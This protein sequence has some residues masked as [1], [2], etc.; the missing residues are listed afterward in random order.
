MNCRSS[1]TIALFAS[2]LVAFSAHAEPLETPDPR[3][4][5]KETAMKLPIAQRLR[6]SN[7]LRITVK[8]GIVDEK[9]LMDL[10]DEDSTQRVEVEGPSSVWTVQKRNI[11]NAGDLVYITIDRYDFDAPP[12]QYW[13]T[14]T[15]I[16]PGGLMFY[17]ARGDNVKGF[18]VRLTQSK[19][20]VSFNCW[21]MDQGLQQVI[22]HAAAPSMKELVARHP[23][24]S[25]QYLSPLLHHLTGRF[26]LRPG[27]G[28]VYR[29]FDKIPADRAVMKKLDQVLLKL[30]SDSFP[31]RE[32]GAKELSAL[33]GPF[34]LAAMRRDNFDLSAEAQERLSQ[35]IADH[36]NFPWDDLPAARQN[37]SVLLDCLDDGDP[38]V[39]AASKAAL[40]KVVGRKIDFDLSL[41][42]DARTAAIN[43]L[44]TTLE[45]RKPANA[46]PA[47]K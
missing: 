3:K 22:F 14:S 20:S 30:E 39:R 10:P 4:V 43:A 34:V 35:F 7:F 28:D 17:A 47:G 21:K 8:D 25:R 27:A 38:A 40:E 6:T 23:N 18:R 2:F 41:E 19:G 15:R 24:E 44:R 5:A 26:L 32:Q 46:A 33:G 42:G 37:R 13:R 36:S 16:T 11:G 31:V 12:D 9:L 29:L 1:V 45:T